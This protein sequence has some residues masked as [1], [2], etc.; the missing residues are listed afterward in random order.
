MPVKW[1][2]EIHL[3]QVDACMQACTGGC[4][5]WGK[6]EPKVQKGFADFRNKK[7]EINIKQRYSSGNLVTA[8]I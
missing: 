8:D 4:I 2:G 3:I 1:S 6:S 7:L 5:N